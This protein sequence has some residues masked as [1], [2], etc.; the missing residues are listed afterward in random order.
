MKFKRFMPPIFDNSY[1]DLWA[2]EKWVVCMEKLFRDLYTEE[3]DR[4]HIAAI[5]LM[6]RRGVGGCNDPTH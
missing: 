6:T 4:V 2:V 1:N 5:A 3:C